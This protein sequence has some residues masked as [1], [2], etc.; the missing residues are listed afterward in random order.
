MH[1]AQIRY[2]LSCVNRAKMHGRRMWYNMWHSLC[3]IKL[4][5]CWFYDLRP[6]NYVAVFSYDAAVHHTEYQGFRKLYTLLICAP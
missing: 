5:R 6:L 4:S 3:I 2:R 1:A